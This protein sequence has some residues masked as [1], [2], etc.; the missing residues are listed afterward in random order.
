MQTARAEALQTFGI[1]YW[2]WDLTEDV[3]SYSSEWEQL[4]GVA[5][6]ELGRSIADSLSSVHPED[7][8]ELTARRA[9]LVLG[10]EDSYSIDYRVRHKSGRWIWVEERSSLFRDANGKP[11]RIVG[12]EIDITDRKHRELTLSESPASSESLELALRDSERKFAILAAAAPVGIFRMDTELNC[13][14]VNERWSELRE[15][16]LESALGHGWMD[17]V[18]PE[19]LA[20]IRE[21]T[22]AFAEDENRIVEEPREARHLLADGSSRWVLVH[23][24]KE[25]D[26]AGNITGYVGTLTDITR[27]KETELALQDAQSQIK[28][29]TDN[30]PGMVF[31]YLLRSD[32]SHALTYVSSKCWELFRVEPEAAIDDADNVFKRIH[33]DDVQLVMTAIRTSAETLQPYKEEFR[34]VL[35]GGEVRWVQDIGEP[36]RT[37]KG[38][39]VWD[40]FVI[41][42]SERKQTELALKE[43]QAKFQRM[44]E[45]VPGMIF[46][47]LLRSD[48]SH[49]VTYVSSKCRELFEVE[50]EEALAD[51]ESLFGH[52]SPEHVEVVLEAVRVSAETLQTYKLE[53]P[54]LLPDQGLSWRQ[55]TSEPTRLENGDTIWDGV[56]L[57]ITDRKETELALQDEQAKFQHLTENVPGMIYRYVVHP[58]G[59]SEFTYVSA[60]SQDVFE[61]EPQAALEDAST[62]WNRI[63]PDDSLRIQEGAEAAAESGTTTGSTYRLVLP[64]KGVRWVQSECRVE[65]HENGD[66]IWDGIVVDITDRKAGELALHEAQAEVQ[67][68]TENVPGLIFQYVVR[69]DGS[70]FMSYVSPNCRDMFEVDPAAAMEN[71]DVLWGRTHPDD[72]EPL[73][74]L[75]QEAFETMLPKKAEFRVVLPQQ[76]VRWLQSSSQPSQLPDGALAMDGII[77]DITDRKTAQFALQQANEELARATRMKDEFLA[78]MSHELRTPLTAI[79]GMNE[80]LQSGIFGPVTHKQRDSYNVI[81]ES[82]DQLLELI[83]EVLDLAKIESGSMELDLGRVNVSKLCESSLQLVAQQ[84]ERKNI[85]L[86]LNVPFNLPDLEADEK[87]L[88]QTLVNLLSNAV[89]FTP[90]GGQVTVEIKKARTPENNEEMLRIAVSD[91]GIGIATDHL[92]TLFDPFVQVDSSLRRAYSGTGLGLALV[93]RFVEMHSGRVTV[94]SKPGAGSCFTIELPFRTAINDTK[95]E[96]QGRTSPEVDSLHQLGSSS[97]VTILLAED[98]TRV[99]AATRM[100]LESTSLNVVLA[101]NGEEAIELAQAH[102]PDVILMDIQMPGIDGFTAIKRLRSISTLENTPIVAV[103]G[104]AMP[105]DEAKCIEAGANTYLSKP[106]SM[107]ELVETIQTHLRRT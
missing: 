63:H 78:N 13:S 99:A 56:V 41:D 23:K 45:N 87:R 31:Q 37:D 55:I 22:Q 85:G 16:P 104:L 26:A 36:T 86:N 52:L 105:A 76:G 43:E 27:I 60:Q 10:H 49:A 81:Q 42:I 100:Y 75:T 8:E 74:Q 21:K 72:L 61:V 54:Y 59:A 15:R 83:N 89:K 44:T 93:K 71:A 96:A 70:H 92:E 80:G 46:Q 6:Q 25:L 30:V 33:P 7:R 29:I 82:G 88:R 9:R 38:D 39:T 103:T 19:D 34:V 95:L 28:R 57:D 68:M 14:Y 53:L 69:P 20:A 66:A 77:V 97:N 101:T 58:D 2:E 35:P 11:A 79:L 102:H 3:V 65:R 17:S 90:N 1:G 62:L 18:H 50:P 98:N 107:A 40:G 64:E 91:T 12:C 94:E 67:R 24:A 84:A 51:V 32:G 106:Y 73:Q 4:R 5:G 47:Y 48:G